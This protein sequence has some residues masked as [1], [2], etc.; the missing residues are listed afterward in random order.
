MMST[1][2][3][4][5][6]TRPTRSGMAYERLR[7]DILAGRLAPETRLPFADLV[8]QY[9]CSIGVLR[10]ALQRL[11]EQGLVV[12]EVQQGFPLSRFPSTTWWT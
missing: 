7:G 12:S 3:G 4:V 2:T 6:G 10:E 9:E 11:Q 1:G 8:R 5:A